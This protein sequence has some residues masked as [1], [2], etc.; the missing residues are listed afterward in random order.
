MTARSIV[1]SGVVVVALLA[2]AGCGDDDDSSAKD[3]TSTGQSADGS[4]DGG[5]T[6]EEVKYCDAVL[7]LETAP[8][9]E[10]DFETMTPDQQAEVVK[11]WTSETMKPLA[12][13]IAAVAPAALA[14]DITVAMDATDKLAETGDFAEFEAPNVAEAL[15]RLH[16]YDLHSCG[17]NTVSLTAKEYMYEGLPSE[18]PAGVTSFELT[19]AGT[20]MHEIA[21]LRKNDGV[22]ETVDELLALPEEE[23]MQKATFL[24]VAFA[25]PGADEYKVADLTPGD[26]IA[27]CFIPVGTTSEDTPPN[28]D[29]PPHFTQGMVHEFTVT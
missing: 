24:G 25:P 21:L 1:I 9:P 4:S 27:L 6:S 14:E 18:L 20:E 12:A 29:A 10:I 22:T 17:W 11:D 2:A 5:A 26:Y 15:D 13:D 8:E 7:A 23:A 3:E 28:P 19:N 16:D